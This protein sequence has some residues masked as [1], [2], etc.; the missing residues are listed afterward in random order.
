MKRHKVC[1]LGAPGV[2]KTSL[3]RRFVEG[4]FDEN[5]LKTLGVKIDRKLVST[6]EGPISL[7]VWDIHGAEAAMPINPR[8]L[9][10]TSG[11]LLVVDGQDPDSARAAVVIHGET[12]AV[13]GADVPYVLCINKSDLVE[14]WTQ[15]DPNIEQLS[16]AAT[17]VLRT[18]ALDGANVEN[19]F[20][21]MALAMSSN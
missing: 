15:G 20:A 17:A 4:V 9:R 1:L 14:D 21:Q 8:H 6:S 16:N 7:I 5:Y 11:Y 18:S 2:G 19:S 12:T 10:G 3:V 13:I